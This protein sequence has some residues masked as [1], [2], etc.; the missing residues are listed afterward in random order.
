MAVSKQDID[1][2]TFEVRFPFESAPALDEAGRR[3]SR[4]IRAAMEKE[5]AN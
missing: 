5:F 1:G 4:E 2:A 3:R